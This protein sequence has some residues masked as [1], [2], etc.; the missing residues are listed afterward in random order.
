M[1]WAGVGAVV[2][3][4]ELLSTYPPRSSRSRMVEKSIGFL[5]MRRYPLTK[6]GFTGSRKGQAAS[7][8]S[9]SIK[10]ILPLKGQ[11]GLHLVKQ[12]H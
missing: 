11:R 10:I 3:E 8:D 4:P 12:I 9:I 2:E 1:S 7:W 6:R 5:M